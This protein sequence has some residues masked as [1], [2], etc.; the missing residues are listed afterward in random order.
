[1]ASQAKSGAK[2]ESNVSLYLQLLRFLLPLVL[3]IIVQE[4]GMQF[5]NGGMARA[6]RATETL[7]GFGLA[8]G[9]V[10]FM[11]SALSQASQLGLVLVDGRPTFKKARLFVLLSGLLLAAVLAG[12][13]LSPLG[14]WVIEGLHQIKRPL[15]LV[16]LESLFW[17]IP[18]P[19]LWGLSRFYSGLLIRIRRTEIIPYA[20][21]ASIGAS[22]LAVFVLLPAGFV[23]AKPIWLPI[24]VTY[25]GI[26]V[27]LA[28]I[29]WGYRTYVS[30]ALSDS[31]DALSLAYIFQFFWPLALIMALQGLSRP[32]IN[33]F[34]SRGP[35]GA[36]ALAVL[37]VVYGLGHLPY[38]WLNEIRNLASAF[39]E[40]GGSLYYIRRFAAGCGLF[41][42]SLMVGLFWTPVRDLILGTF[43]GL[44][45][46]L[47]SQAAAPLIIFSFF[48]FAV[49]TRA[50]LHGVG[51][52]ERRTKA[53][54]PSAP[55][56]I[57]A[58]LMMLTLLPLLGMHG[59]T[60]GVTALFSGFVGE[61]IAVWWG[62]H[63]RR[64]SY[65]SGSVALL[66]RLLK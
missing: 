20:I 2:V 47:A 25:A 19:L 24:L 50:Y 5:M 66:Q 33:L 64:Y 3:T 44:E 7:A 4:F 42:F 11:T 18:I 54:A 1:M 28:V 55:S 26:L 39:K 43:I 15:S 30:P 62:V 6:P 52:L 21:T 35:N 36:E 60:L 46:A 63:G 27:E 38:G 34:V 14:I 51:L 13:V 53:M 49:A 17:L 40:V 31:G 65:K 23:Q 32:L 45:V 16:A 57:G 37:T 12:L 59:A 48:P 8:W 58:I 29:L 10:S 56:R 9:L 22:I 61:T 41:S